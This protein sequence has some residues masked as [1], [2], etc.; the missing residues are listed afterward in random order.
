MAE[1]PDAAEV[2]SALAKI[3]ELYDRLGAGRQGEIVE[4]PKGANPDHHG[5]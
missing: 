5:G 1:A 3:K 2:L 4:W